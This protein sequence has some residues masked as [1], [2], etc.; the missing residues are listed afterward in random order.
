MQFPP[1]TFAA[2]I[3]TLRLSQGLYKPTPPAS[4]LSYSKTL[5]GTSSYTPYDSAGTGD[6]SGDDPSLQSSSDSCAWLP[7]DSPVENQTFAP[8]DLAK[9][10]VYRYR[11][12]QSVNLGSW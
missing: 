3:Q 1:S 10:A 6:S 8:F 5:A 12:Q 2:L 7:Y 4:P 9:A 11:Q